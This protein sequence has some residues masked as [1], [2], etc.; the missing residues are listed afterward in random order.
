M[1]IGKVSENVLKRSVFKQIQ[2]R[3]SEVL[4][5]PG[6]GEDCAAMSVEPDEV[7]VFST[8]PITGADKQMGVFAVHIT[9][10]DLAT[11][12][13]EPVGILTSII[14]P[15]DTEEA[16]LRQIMKEMEDV[17]AE[18]QIEI[19]G[20]HTEVSD[21]VNRPVIT[22]TGIGK[23]KRDALLSTGG[24]Q[25][26]DELVM[27][28]WAGLEGSAII[29]G[30]KRE[31]LLQRLPVELV[32][33]AAGFLKHLSVVP[34]AR[35]AVEYGATAMHDVTEGGIFGALWEMGAASGVGITVDLCKIPICQETVE[36]CEVFDINP[37]LLISSGC[38]LIGCKQGNL[39]VEKL[40]EAGI[41]AAVIGRATEG[42]DRI[43]RNGEET[44]FIEPP[45]TDELYKIY[46]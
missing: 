31:E 5:H 6:V 27:T 36:I 9:A 10:N 38:M 43:V 19:L 25:P 18:L 1:K 45:G 32:E 11:A 8:D 28:K 34:E 29:A 12:G 41:P 33:A 20:G 46:S 26:G 44:R 37:Y 39:L 3:R 40:D 2:H 21:V 15:P 23:V 17:C 35:I 42:N 16:Q 22:V 13:A 14:L 4:L 24:L 30:E 7:L